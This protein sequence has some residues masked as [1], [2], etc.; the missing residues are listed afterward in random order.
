MFEVVKKFLVILLFAFFVSFGMI[1]LTKGSFGKT[2]KTEYRG[3]ITQ[4]YKQAGYRG[5]VKN[6]VVFYCDSL[7]RKIDVEITNNQYVNLVVGQS[8][9]KKLYPNQ[10]K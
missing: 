8:Y 5:E 4:M 7:K 1:F 2:G 3:K 10:T 6:H 9:S